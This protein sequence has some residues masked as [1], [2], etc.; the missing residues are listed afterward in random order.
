M[1]AA[2]YN[3]YV[4]RLRAQL[5]KEPGLV[6]HFHSCPGGCSA[7]GAEIKEAEVCFS[8]AR[9]L[10]RDFQGQSGEKGPLRKHK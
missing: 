1:P 2:G 8:T 5:A 6:S 3:S 4:E 9:A 7:N 10:G